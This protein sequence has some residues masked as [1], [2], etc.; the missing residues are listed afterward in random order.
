M[1]G[2]SA[3]N[4]ERNKD[5]IKLNK[6]DLTNQNNEQPKIKSNE[7][8]KSKNFLSFSRESLVKKKKV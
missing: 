2:G 5:R 3:H 7:L 8:K 6:I 1:A 4:H